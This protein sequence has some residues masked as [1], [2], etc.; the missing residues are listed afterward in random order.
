MAFSK[1]DDILDPIIEYIRYNNKNIDANDYVN[2]SPELNIRLTDDQ[3]KDSGVSSWNISIINTS[4]NSVAQ[5]FTGNQAT[6]VAI[7][8]LTYTNFTLPNGTYITR[9]NVSDAAGNTTSS[10]TA[11][12][13]VTTDL[14]IT[15]AMNGPNPF[16]PN[17]ETTQIQYQ[18]SKDADVSLYIYSISGEMLV[19]NKFTMGS[20]GSTAGFNSIAWDGRNRFNERVSN[21]IYIAYIIARNGD[22]TTVGKVKIAVLK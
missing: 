14:L 11:T 1:K 5:S 6:P 8:D 20:S 10:T 13:N 15:D 17:I 12:F 22:D 3:A 9:V 19:S 4:D 18:L 21:G 7:K 2:A 16:N